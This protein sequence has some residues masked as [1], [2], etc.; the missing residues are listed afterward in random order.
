MMMNIY[1]WKLWIGNNNTDDDDSPNHDTINMLLVFK[2][3]E[4]PITRPA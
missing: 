1:E 3:L 2:I 4:M